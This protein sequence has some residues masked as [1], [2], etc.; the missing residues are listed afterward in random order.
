MMETNLSLIPIF[1]PHFSNS[2]YTQINMLRNYYV[3]ELLHGNWFKRDPK[4]FSFSTFSAFLNFKVSGFFSKMTKPFLAIV[5]SK[6][7]LSFLKITGSTALKIFDFLFT[8]KIF[9]IY[10][11]L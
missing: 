7:I 9:E 11:I 1:E 2:T 3:I 8:E 5:Q 10:E 6:T 4:S